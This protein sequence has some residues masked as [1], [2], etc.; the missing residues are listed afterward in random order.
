MIYYS[1]DGCSSSDGLLTSIIVH[2][3]RAKVDQLSLY[4]VLSRYCV[5]IIMQ[6]NRLVKQCAHLHETTYEGGINTDDD[7]A[8]ASAKMIMEEGPNNQQSFRLHLKQLKAH[9]II[10]NNTLKNKIINCKNSLSTFKTI[11]QQ[12]LLPPTTTTSSSSTTATTTKPSTDVCDHE[13]KDIQFALNPN[14]IKIHQH[15]PAR[16]F[17]FKSYVSSIDYMLSMMDD[18]L[19]VNETT[20]SLLYNHTV[21]SVSAINSLSSSSS[22]SS[23]SSAS[24]SSSSSPLSSVLTIDQL[25][26]TSVSIHET[27]PQLMARCYYL[28]TLHILSP[29]LS[30]LL[31]ASMYA[32][33]LPHSM[34]DSDLVNK[35]WLC[36]NPTS[37]A[38]DL[39]KG[40]YD[41]V[42]D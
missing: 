25:I 5:D 42:D 8:V 31:W 39:L 24:S 10:I 4:H 37:A 13:L 17:E 36:E 22:S 19:L 33:G 14:L 12:L 21:D 28:S 15:G 16:K 20:I 2:V 34:I 1:T 41:D 7:A 38:W 30:Q 6:Y 29:D 11:L 27:N 35:K 9:N 26:T 32:S 23:S 40:N 3:L 18:M